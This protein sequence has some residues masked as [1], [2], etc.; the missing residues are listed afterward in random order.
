MYKSLGRSGMHVKHLTAAVVLL[1]VLLS[2]SSWA[3]CSCN[4]AIITGGNDSTPQQIFAFSSGDSLILCGWADTIYGTAAWSEFD[5]LDCRNDSVVY[6]LSAVY[7]AVV[8]FVHD[9]LSISILA[10]LPL[11]S[12][13]RYRPVL[14]SRE[15][16][17]HKGRGFMITSP[18]CVAHIR[19]IAG[20]T[21]QSI[22]KRFRSLVQKHKFLEVESSERELMLDKILLLALGSN[23]EASEIY[24][25][26]DRMGFLDG[27]LAEEWDQGIEILDVCSRHQR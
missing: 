5:I 17:L 21:A 11:D 8:D 3:G 2:A 25:N 10:M 22:L 15:M 26:M 12:G 24:R 6:E 18:E 13:W 19:T 9:T 7:S 20:D 27:H 23:S 1:V 4:N 16:I 14:V